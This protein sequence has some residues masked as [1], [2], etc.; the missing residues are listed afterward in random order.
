MRHFT[1]QVV[2]F[3]KMRL[4]RASPT[5]RPPAT[6]ARIGQQPKRRLHRRGPI[7][8][9]LLPNR[10]IRGTTIQHSAQTQFPIPDAAPRRPSHDQPPHACERSRETDP[11]GP[12][13]PDTGSAHQANTHRHSAPCLRLGPDPR[14]TAQTARPSTELWPKEQAAT[15]NAARV[16]NPVLPI[17]GK[18][19]EKRTAAPAASHSSRCPSSCMAPAT[20]E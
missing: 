14:T 5:L 11:D 3:R 10:T 17:N 18:H 19:D 13:V 20:A 2:G 4:L 6:E 12:K 7:A 1:M 16:I 9:S 15:K 8:P